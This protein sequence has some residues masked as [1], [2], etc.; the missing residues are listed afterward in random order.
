MTGR[1]MRMAALL[2]L[3]AGMALAQDG[4]TPGD[5]TD[6]D[7]D[8]DDRAA[9]LRADALGA[10][11]TAAGADDVRARLCHGFLSTA[12]REGR[13]GGETTTG[14]VM[15]AGEEL[16]AWETA[17]SS[18]VAAWADLTDAAAVEASDTAWRAFRDADCALQ[19]L[20]W[21]G[22]SLAR[23][24][25]TEC[26]LSRTVDRAIDLRSRRDSFSGP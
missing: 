16:A 10:C 12:C 2:C 15:C 3:T 22:G 18:E 21:E 1:T 23:V 5:G 26:L 19:A 9:T 11:L 14:L 25:E 6:A 24:E 7:A 8:A 20:R 17:L 4:A 13:P